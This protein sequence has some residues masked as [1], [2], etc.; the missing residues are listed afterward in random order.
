[1]IRVNCAASA[2]KSGVAS[3]PAASLIEVSI[4]RSDS[5]APV[6]LS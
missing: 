5:T 1:M 6:T 2:P 3:E 4:L